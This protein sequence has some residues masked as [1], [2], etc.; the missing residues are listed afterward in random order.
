[1]A[2]NK[3]KQSKPNNIIEL[4]IVFP[5]GTAKEIMDEIR[6]VLNSTKFNKISINVGTYR[7]ILDDTIPKD[8][9]RVISVGYIKKIDSENGDMTIGLYEANKDKILALKGAVVDIVYTEYKG[10]LGTILK[11]IIRPYEGGIEVAGE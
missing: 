11:F 2:N 6:D 1:M 10:K 7:N 4:P 8:D 9:T 3:K 5:A